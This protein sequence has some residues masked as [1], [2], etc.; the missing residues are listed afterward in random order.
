MAVHE[1]NRELIRRWRSALYD[2]DSR[3]LAAQLKA[4]VAADAPIQL[5]HPL[6]TLRGPTRYTNRPTRRCY[7]PSR[8]LS[9]A[10]TS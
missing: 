3:L 7:A 1:Q 2:L 5:A 8:T 4:L 6:G 10:T 9:V